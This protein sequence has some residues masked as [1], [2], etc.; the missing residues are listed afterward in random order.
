MTFGAKSAHVSDRL[1][2][3]PPEPKGSGG[4]VG[5]GCGGGGVG[6]GGGGG[7]VGGGSSGGGQLTAA[8]RVRSSSG[9]GGNR[10]NAAAARTVRTVALPA[11]VSASG[12]VSSPAAKRIKVEVKVSSV[13]VGSSV[14]H[15]S[16]SLPA[17]GRQK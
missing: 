7:G 4:G 12:A 8:A 17:L 3:P 5:S 6:G 2:L 10:R 13:A 14:F 16:V 9:R 15:K 1:Y 11:A